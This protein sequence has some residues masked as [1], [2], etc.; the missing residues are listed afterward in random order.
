[1]GKTKTLSLFP[2]G[3]LR[4]RSQSSMDQVTGCVWGVG[5][6]GGSTGVT[7]SVGSAK[8]WAVLLREEEK[9]QEIKDAAQVPSGLEF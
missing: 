7:I 9:P 1:M 6:S 3:I 2:P 8:E 5:W 4:E